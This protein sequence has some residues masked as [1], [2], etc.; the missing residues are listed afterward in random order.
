MGGGLRSRVGA[1]RPEWSPDGNQWTNYA[2]PLY[3]LPLSGVLIIVLDLTALYFSK[4]H[5]PRVSVNEI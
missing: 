1:S 3:S 4:L 5:L 2:M